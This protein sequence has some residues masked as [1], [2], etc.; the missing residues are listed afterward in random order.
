VGLAEET[1]KFESRYLDRL[2]A[3]WPE[4]RAVYDERSPIHHL[5]GFRAPLIVFQG[6]EDKVVPPSQS[7]AIVA[8]LKSKGIPV[9]YIEFEGEQHGFR[10]AEN[11]VRSLEAELA[12]YGQVFGFVPA[13][14][15][16]RPQFE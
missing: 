2:V 14:D 6:S 7:R 10:R 5:E 3:P 15:L 1:H 4:G 16:P 11:I 12:F 13:G 8:A 9:A